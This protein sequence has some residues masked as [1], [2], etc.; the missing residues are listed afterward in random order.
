MRVGVLLMVAGFAAVA[1]GAFAQTPGQSPPKG[2]LFFSCD[3]AERVEDLANA[4]L[5]EAS[6]SPEARAADL[7]AARLAIDK[8]VKL[9]EAALSGQPVEAPY[10]G[11]THFANLATTA[12]S[13]RV[14]ELFRRVARDQFGRSHFTAAMQRASWAAGLSDNALAYAYYFV[15][16]DGCGVD[17]GNTAWLKADLLANGWPTIPQFGK[18]AD[19]AAFLLVQHAD[20]DRAFQSQVLALLEPLAK[21]GRTRPANY[22]YLFDRVAVANKQPQRYGTQGRCTG[23]GLWEP[24]EVEAPQALDARRASLGMSSE[25]EYKAR[26]SSCRG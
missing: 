8:A 3:A 1:S 5:D 24:F 19:Q 17:E 26:F 9:R 23:V 20:R 7:A 25:A 21:D 16:R 11:V 12:T 14:A 6:T 15:A 22:A 10:G 4:K 13:P 18:D 2:A